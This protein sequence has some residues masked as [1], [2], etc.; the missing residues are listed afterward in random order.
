DQTVSV[1]IQ[2]V[3]SGYG[4]RPPRVDF[5]SVAISEVDLQNAERVGDVQQ[6]AIIREGDTIRIVNA[7]R[8]SDL[9]KS[10]RFVIESVDSVC[11]TVRE[12]NLVFATENKIVE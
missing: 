1:P 4:I 6:V 7:A 11:Q 5:L 12:I 8:E 3:G 9:G 10:V 2:P